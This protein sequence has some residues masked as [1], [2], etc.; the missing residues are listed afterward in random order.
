MPWLGP[1]L[2][3]LSWAKCERTEVGSSL[4]IEWN[5]PSLTLPVLLLLM[6]L[7]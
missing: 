6:V 3:D 5:L 7:G 2:F 4:L 1:L